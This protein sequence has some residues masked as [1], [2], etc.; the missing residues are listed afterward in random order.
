MN[1]EITITKEDLVLWLDRPPSNDDLD[2]CEYLA[3]AV[4]NRQKYYEENQQLKE[5][6]NEY[7]RLGFKHL[8]EKRNEL[9]QENNFLKADNIH[10]RKIRDNLLIEYND[11]QQEK[12]QLKEKYL[13]AVADYETTKS[14][15]QQLK[16][17]NKL[18]E[19][20]Y[21]QGEKNLGTQIDITLKYEKVLDEIR[22]YIKEQLKFCEND[23]QGAYEICNL[24][25]RKYKHLLQILDKVKGE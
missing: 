9:E 23:S 11:L 19:K 4:Q 25:I 7:R 14:E 1:E 6:M 16:D 17:R 12:Q 13:N 2:L 3:N 22:E 5:K 8:Q 15:N 20:H 18:L 24:T 21:K 10:V